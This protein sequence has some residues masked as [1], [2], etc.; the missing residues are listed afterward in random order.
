MFPEGIVQ[1]IVGACCLTALMANT[2]AASGQHVHELGYVAA[3]SGAAELPPNGS[4]GVGSARVMIDLALFTMR[5][6]V[7][8]SGLLGNVAA[9]Q[10]HGITPFAGEGTAG[11]AIVMPVFPSGVTAGTYDRTLDLTTASTYHPDFIAA[12]GGTISLASNALFSGL[13]AG[14]TYLRIQTTAFDGGEIRGFLLPTP[15]ADFN[16][17]GVVDLPDLAVWR[18]AF[19]IE[20]HG[21]ASGDGLTDGTDLLLWQQ[22]LGAVASLPGGHHHV[23]AVP[24]PGS[25]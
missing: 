17:N 25:V 15:K 6:E 1:K 14:K 3:L 7:E 2:P 24:D 5:V 21:D 16:F 23:L 10:I 11:P 22:Q 8:F 13:S 19:G 20:H 4:P 12:S 9:A 18:E